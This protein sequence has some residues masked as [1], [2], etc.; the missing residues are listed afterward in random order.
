MSPPRGAAAARGTPPGATW[1]CACAGQAASPL[2]RP[3]RSAARRQAHQ[4][5]GLTRTAAALP[6]YYT[7]RPSYT[8]VS[9]TLFSAPV[10]RSAS[11]C[12]F[13]CGPGAAQPA[14]ARAR[15]HAISCCRIPYLQSAISRHA[16][17]TRKGRGLARHTA[18]HATGR[19]DGGQACRPSTAA[20]T[21]QLW[22]MHARPTCGFPISR[23]PPIH[24]RCLA[25]CQTCQ[26]L[27]RAT[28]RLSRTPVPPSLPSFGSTW[29]T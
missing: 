22:H 10:F 21:A 14:P 2:S 15:R 16:G 3:Q 29:C 8:T 18:V 9:T 27:F 6:A 24:Q 20:A 25:A 11:I 5:S 19:H 1:R 28:A 12:N 7:P 23:V 17:C 4:A 26:T 13:F